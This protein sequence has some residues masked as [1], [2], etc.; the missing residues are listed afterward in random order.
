MPCS[1][2]RQ[3]TPAELAVIQEQTS[4]AVPKPARVRLLGVSPLHFNSSP[5]SYSAWA[6]SECRF[7]QG[8]HYKVIS[9]GKSLSGYTSS[10]WLVNKGRDDEALAVL[11]RARGLPSDS[12][13]IQ[14]EFLYVI[15]VVRMLT[16]GFDLVMTREIKAQHI[17]EQEISANKY[18]HLQD[19]SFR[20]DFKLGALEYLSLLRTRSTLT[21][22]LTLR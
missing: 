21:S 2:R 9:H 18:P 3:R 16:L 19:G 6:Y 13:L 5:P 11:S 4:L 10:R 15:L 12:E 22:R 14:I 7:P 17:F 8:T 1:I 20:S